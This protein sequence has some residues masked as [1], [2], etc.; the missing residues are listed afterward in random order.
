[1]EI[2][3]KDM[4]QGDRIFNDLILYVSDNLCGELGIICVLKVE[5]FIFD[6]IYV[7]MEFKIICFIICMNF[8]FYYGIVGN[9]VGYIVIS[10]FVI[11][12]CLKDIKKVLIEL[13]Q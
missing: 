13:K 6:S 1:M 9:N 12:N 3:G 10:I 7:L 11:E 2:N 8:V 5:R 4:V